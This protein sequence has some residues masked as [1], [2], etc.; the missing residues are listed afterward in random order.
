MSAEQVARLFE[1]FSQADSTIAQ[2]F[3]GTGL[4]LAISQRFVEMLGGRITI[5]S[6]PGAGSCFT[7]W[8]PDVE[9]K[10]QDGM[11]AATGPRILII[12]DTLSDISLLERYLTPLGY[13]IEVA[14]NGEQGLALARKITPEAILLDLELPG[15]DG[16]G[17]MR[18]LSA[19]EDVVAIPVIVT[20]VHDSSEQA[21]KLGARAYITKPIDRHVLQTALNANI[22]GRRHGDKENGAT[23][24]A[25][26]ATG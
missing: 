2:R 16:P 17:V 13:Q 20:S 14:R 24:L 7:V 15:I 26:A 18:A 12:E 3:G 19:D 21:L 6:E 25:Q 10:N 9:F 23:S 8:I 11:G 22:R 4:G 5:D 1:P